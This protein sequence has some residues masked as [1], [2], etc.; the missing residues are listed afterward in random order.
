MEVG[1]CQGCDLPQ[2]VSDLTSPYSFRWEKKHA[3]KTRDGMTPATRSLRS[4]MLEA[5]KKTNQAR[6]GARSLFLR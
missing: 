3:K 4:G 1:L 2:E 5:D 6:G